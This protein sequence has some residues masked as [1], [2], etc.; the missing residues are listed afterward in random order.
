MRK[1]TVIFPAIL[2]LGASL[3]VGGC[4]GAKGM[5]VLVGDAQNTADTAQHNAAAAMLAAQRAQSTAD[6]AAQ[7]AQE[8]NLAALTAQMKIDAMAGEWHEQQLLHHRRHH[9]RHHAAKP[10]T[11]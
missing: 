4:T 10:K 9:H 3:L 8:A 5:Y 11:P 2:M 1:F 7:R 6:A